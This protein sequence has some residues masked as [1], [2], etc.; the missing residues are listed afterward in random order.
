[1]KPLAGDE[2]ANAM[3]ARPMRE[4]WGV[5]PGGTRSI[6]MSC[7]LNS[8][9]AGAAALAICLLGA[10]LLMAEEGFEPLFNGK[11]LDDWDVGTASAWQVRDGVII[12]K[13]PGLKYN[14]FLRTK[15]H[16]SDFVLK[17]TM[18]IIG[19]KGNSGIQFRSKPVPDS[20]EVSGYQADAGTRA[21]GEPIW[22]VLY[23]ECRRKVQLAAPPRS[24]LDQFDP[25]EWHEYVITAQGNRIRLEVDGVTTVDY[26]EKEPGIEQTGFIALQA[27][28]H[29]GPIEVHFKDLWIKEPR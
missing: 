3:L 9:R 24:V 19:G 10:G 25:K 13:T 18:R 16:Y 26:E 27:H 29:P 7:E 1:M 8:I 6:I 4:P 28:S 15:K 5:A 12:G 21:N 14:E 23:D 20:H 2:G 17:A 22:G 11:N